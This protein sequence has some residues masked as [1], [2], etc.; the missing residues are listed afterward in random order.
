MCPDC[1]Q[2]VG[3]EE[4]KP[5]NKERHPYSGRRMFSSMPRLRMK[6]NA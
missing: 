2:G 3:K 6:I 4:A 5:K 1:L